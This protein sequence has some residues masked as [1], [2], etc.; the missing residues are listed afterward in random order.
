MGPLARLPQQ[1]HHR[2]ARLVHAGADRRGEYL[3]GGVQPSATNCL[4]KRRQRLGRLAAR[5]LVGLGQ[6]QVAR[7]LGGEAEL[8]HLAIELL[9]RMADIDDQHQPAQ[10]AALVQVGVDLQLP[11]LAHLQRHLG[12]AVTGQIDQADVQRRLTVDLQSA[13]AG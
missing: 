7:Q 4:R 1:A 5:E 3:R 2:C 12:V 9:Q 8:Q 11:V 13:A 6:Q 10:A